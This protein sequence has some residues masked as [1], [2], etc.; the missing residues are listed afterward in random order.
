MFDPEIH[1]PDGA[2]R[3][4]PGASPEARKPNGPAPTEPEDERPEGDDPVD[5]LPDEIAGAQL[6]DEVRAFLGRFIVY[7]S[8]AAHIAH[9]LWIAHA[10]LMDAWESTPR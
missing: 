5:I 4:K 9:T 1:I 6:L 7:P 10:H 2:G 8:E 3:P